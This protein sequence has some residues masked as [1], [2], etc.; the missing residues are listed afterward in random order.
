VQ[1]LALAFLKSSIAT[2][3]ATTFVLIRREKS[4]RN[5]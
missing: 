2:P 3:L 1:E 5:G 4:S